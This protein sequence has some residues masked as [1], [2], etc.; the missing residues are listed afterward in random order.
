MKKN[1]TP[2]FL[3]LFLN[4]SFGQNPSVPGKF[5]PVPVSFAHSKNNSSTAIP[6][7]R[8]CGTMEAD[9][10]LRAGNPALGTLQ[11]FEEWL[12]KKIAL[13]AEAGIKMPPVY[14]IPVIVHIIH[15][16][17]AI[18]SG[19]NISQ[20]Q[21]NSQFDVLNEDFRMTNADASN[22]P[23]VFQSVSADVEIQFCPA[24]VDP[25]GNTLAQ[26]GI[27]R[28]NRT[29]KGFTSPPYS[30]SYIDGTI[31][32]NTYW[33]PARYFNIWVLN[34]SNSLLGYA[35]FPSNSGLSGLNSNGGAA[36]TDGI[37][38]LY[39]AFGRVGNVS[40]PFNRGR[41]ATHEAGHW[42]G[43]RHIWGDGSCATD[44]C[45]DTPTADQSHSGCPS[46]PYHTNAC[47][48]GSSSNGEMFMNYM[49]YTNDACMYMFTQNQRTRMRTVMQ[50]SP[51]RVELITSTVCNSNSPPVCGFT[52]TSFTVTEGAAINYTDQSGGTPTT[53]S[54]TFQGGTPASSTLQNPAG[55]VYNTAGTYNTTLVATNSYGTCT[56]TQAVTVAP[57]V[58]CDTLNYPPPG[59]LVT[60]TG[61]GGYV[62]GWNTTYKDI[63][64]ADYFASYSPYTHVTGGLIYFRSAYRSS[65]SNAT[66]SF[67]VWNNTG[68]GGS[69]GLVLGSK[70]ITLQ[71]LDAAIPA[72]GALYQVI[73]DSPIPVTTPFYFGI[74]MNNFANADSLGIVSNTNGDSNP[75]TA[76]EQWSDNAWY[77]FNDANSWGISVSQF[78]SP[79]MTNLPPDAIFTASDT[80]ACIGSTITFNGSSSANETSY[81]WS[82]TGGSPASS[83]SASQAVT[84]NAAG[85]YKAILT[86]GG[87]C[88]GT[89][90]DSVIN[91]VINP[92]PSVTATAANVTCNGGNNG[93]ATATP[94]GGTSPYTYS[95]SNGQSVATAT[96]L[97]AGTYTV[98]V[99]DNK[100]CS[101]NAS[102]VVTQP[103]ALTVS[104]SSTN[105]SCGGTNGSATAVPSGG[106]SPY[107]FLW[108]NGQTTATASGLSAGTYT[109]TVTDNSGCTQTATATVSSSG[110]GLNATTSANNVTCNGGNDGT[111]TATPGGGTSPYNYNWNSTPSQSA[112]TATG[113]SPG[114]YSVTI[115]DANTCS[116]VQS[117]T[118]SQPSALSLSASQ[119]EGTCGNAN[120][121]A[122]VNASGGISPYA[123]LWSNGQTNSTATG[124]AAGNYTVTVTDANN[125]TVTENFTLVNADSP[126]LSMSSANVL[127]NGNNNGSATVTPT[128][129]TNP[130]TYNWSNGGTTSTI[131]NLSPGTYS[132]TVTDANNCTSTSSA[133][134]T[135]PGVLNSSAASTNT[136]CN[137]ACDGAVSA[138]A[139]SGT[140]PYNYT[141][142]GTLGTGSGKTNVCAGTYTVTV[143]DANNCSSTASATVNQPAAIILTS[144]S[145][146]ATCGSLNGSATI[147]ASGGA[148]GFSYL[149]NNGQTG[150]TATGLI[151]GTYTV[152][153]TDASGCSNS[154]NV[155]VSNDIPTTLSISSENVSCYGGNNGSATAV[156][157]GGTLPYSYTWSNGSNGSGINSLAAGTYTVTVS[158]ANNCTAIQSV[159]ISEPDS[160]ALNPASTNISCTGADNGSVSVNVSGGTSPYI[161][162]WSNGSTQPIINN[163]TAGTYSVTVTDTNNCSNTASIP[164][165]EPSALSSA[166]T[167]TAASCNGV[168]NG[169]LSASSS[170]GTSPYMYNWSG[171]L[172]SGADQSGVCAGSYTITITDANNCTT[173]SS[174]TV[175]QPS[176]INLSMSS[177]N[178]T[179]GVSNGSASVSAA[180]GSGGFT[181]SWNTGSTNPAITGLSA[182]TYT[183]TVTDAGNCSNTASITVSN[184]GAP[185][186]TVSSTSPACNGT[187]NGSVTANVNGGNSPYSFQ[188]SNGQ[189]SA[190]AT[191]VCAG[192]YT[193][194]VT[195]A[196]NC[197]ASS[198]VTVSQPPALIATVSVNNNPCL[199]SATAGAS[200]GTSGYSYLWSNGQN[201]QTSTGLSAGTYTVTV[202]DANN[203]NQTASAD[204]TSNP[205][206]ITASATV[207]DVSCNGA[208]DGLAAASASGGISPYNYLWSNGQGT[209]SATGLSAGTYY[210]TVTDANGCSGSG[211]AAISEPSLLTGPASSTNVSCNG[212]SNGTASATASG[213]ISPYTYLWST[214]AG[215]PNI[216]SLPSGT[217]S[218]SIT[219]NNG[220]TSV[221]STVV[222]E[223]PALTLV[224]TSNPETC[225]MNNGTGTVN[226]NGGT[227]PYIYQWDANAGSQTAQ[228]ATGL[229]G[230]IG[231]QYLVIVQDA[232]GC[233]SNIFV[234]VPGTNAVTGSL[235]ASEANCGA[236]DGSVTI[237]AS[238]GTPPYSYLWSNGATTSQ[239]SNLPSQIYTVTVTDNAGCTFTASDTVN[240]KPGI[241][242]TA[243]SSPSQCGSNNGLATVT[244]SG[245]V[246][247]YNYSW[248]NGDSSITAD[249]LF[250]GNY[251][252]I[253]TDVNGCADTAAVVVG[254][255]ILMSVNPIISDENCGKSDGVAIAGVS[256]GTSPYSFQWS[257]S[258]AQTVQVA[259]G[260]K[261]GIYN[262]TVTD[263]DNCTA[264]S[265]VSIINTSN[266]VINSLQAAGGHCGSSNGTVASSASGGPLPYT[267]L[268]SNG[269][270]TSTANGMVAGTY[271]VTITDSAGC[272][273][274]S[275]IFVGST[276]MAMTESVIAE[277]CDGKKDAGIDISVSGGVAPYSF[278]WS[279]DA[280]SEDLNNISAGGYTV[281][282]TDANGCPMKD[283][284]AVGL[285]EE[286][287]CL[288]IPSGFTPNADGKNDTWKIRG[289]GNY[290]D[291]KVEI[292]NRW[293]SLVFSSKGYQ[294]PWDGTN[295]GIELPSAAYY[296]VI[297]LGDGTTKTGSV[298]IVR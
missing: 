275:T 90:K 99:S 248:S 249:S 45:S 70:T 98:I 252:V 100:G 280:S 75:N 199:I 44:Y 278:K 225:G 6:P 294:Q 43:L 174:A 177:S 234:P 12:Q 191:S 89:D 82:F 175:A 50:N 149:W 253:V 76:W 240:S 84:Y 127:C 163:L 197:V 179:C 8:T 169:T 59:T 208:N 85:T 297:T 241:T 146:Q 20:A 101:S 264:V 168:C 251:S 170:G 33:D 79:F 129:G 250:A 11:N 140:S 49:D 284:I 105:A 288:D 235:S 147:N 267:Y 133:T 134:I 204:V 145:T 109:V 40:S 276:L 159:V 7:S 78:M 187:C 227:A 178:A 122:T 2:V 226:A 180:G 123:Y 202:T 286:N 287:G 151:A 51:R 298:T 39:T 16:G 201:T 243:A 103:S 83:S 10:L 256:G 25:N 244:V 158:D 295:N 58:G 144:S 97:A 203:C 156:P 209:A 222:S 215:T 290:P 230:G 165:T 115:T 34:L 112:Q 268:W 231:I 4:L 131:N 138:L 19:S 216:T 148:G 13:D 121:S 255:A 211:S 260:L 247:P 172:G 36:S 210:F 161:Y 46:H 28:V 67:R 200:G 212:G 217:Y 52:A 57:N 22:I 21:V 92:N 166:A 232:N 73:F 80:D 91:I 108:N 198:T 54:W 224:S 38:V 155:S 195:D 116:V 48:N 221:S 136:S 190:T 160:I 17:E 60:Y 181:Y 238:G 113:L 228:T 254:G 282:V 271:S 71:S 53:W 236:A 189:T 55:I 132:V 142:S 88:Q 262:V 69:P 5:A 37:V 141:W 192:S 283:T 194:T 130:I 167:A 152:T 42:L 154:T 184:P 139:S 47:G 164:I 277:T 173:V 186:L 223:P 15:N 273:V 126:S 86:V 185:A 95:W 205:T 289:I 120:G 285:L 9:S 29:S 65:G 291:I 118:I 206:N 261:E 96:G 279:N 213:G 64:K 157:G 220:C 93:S 233:A 265:T 214:G 242:I 1:F 110:G 272:K 26:P 257:D 196:T 182:G 23:G 229:N 63:S 125:C 137:G 292:Y 246:S 270:T 27:D 81:S 263:A 87:S 104:A 107:N 150:S 41:T 193:V 188:W 274:T 218:I 128:G 94:S 237:N 35:Q 24:V 119:N 114:T 74:T 219:D 117:V 153:I 72:G 143:T 106:N 258:N 56:L 266:L 102:V 176:N 245:G 124:L 77:P 171:G 162:S 293:G 30:Q 183:V 66:V 68:T 207:A 32:P 18:G 259:V 31:K 62:S 111:A 281:I 296:Y 239:I 3:F 135:Q 61:G 269:D 14:T